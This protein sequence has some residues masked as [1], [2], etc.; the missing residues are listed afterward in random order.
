MKPENLLSEE[1]KKLYA[2]SKKR[3]KIGATLRESVE[4]HTITKDGRK[5]W[6]HLNG[7]FGYDNQNPSKAIVQCR[8][9]MAA[10]SVDDRKRP[11]P[12]R[13]SVE[14]SKVCSEALEKVIF[15]E[16]FPRTTVD[17]F[18]EVL[19]ADAGREPPSPG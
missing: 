14:I 3:F 8:Y 13:R 9:N 6:M 15:T 17:V 19:Q 5:L 18:I 16:Q 10:F 11:G 7:F 4:Y 12:D 1:S 2:E